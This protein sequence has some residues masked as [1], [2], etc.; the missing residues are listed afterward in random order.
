[1]ATLPKISTENEQK[2]DLFLTE[3]KAYSDTNPCP[4]DFDKLCEIM[5]NCYFTGHTALNCFLRDN[6]SLKEKVC[7]YKNGNFKKIFCQ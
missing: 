3:L 1:M 6:P 5:Y 2:I 7:E 4:V